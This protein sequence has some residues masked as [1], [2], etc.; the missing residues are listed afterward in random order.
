M[1]PGAGDSAGKEAAV[2]RAVVDDVALDGRIRSKP[3]GG[4]GVDGQGVVLIAH[5]L[6]ICGDHRCAVFVNGQGDGIGTDLEPPVFRGQRGQGV[7]GAF[8]GIRKLM[9]S[10][11]S[12]QRGSGKY[13]FS[14][15]R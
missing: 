1:L 6:C 14:V 2:Q 11:R 10:A 5:A 13:Y 15:H 9:V 4:V 8:V 3:R 7:S 12:T